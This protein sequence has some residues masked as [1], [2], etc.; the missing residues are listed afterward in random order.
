MAV[1]AALLG[2]LVAQAGGTIVIENHSP[3][4]IKVAA[5]GGSAVV[6]PGA[7]PVGVTFET[8]EERGVTLRI[9]W[10]SN[11]RQLCQI[12]VPWDRTVTVSGDTQILCLSR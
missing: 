9:W 12:V 11:P 7:P 1:A 10:V 2:P 5:P 8:E 3:E 6:E 4:R